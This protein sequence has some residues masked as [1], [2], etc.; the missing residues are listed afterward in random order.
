MSDQ[1]LGNFNDSE[2][3][4][5]DLP[6]EEH[7]LLGLLMACD[8]TSGI[9]SGSSQS[10]PPPASSN[11]SYPPPANLPINQ[12]PT[13]KKNLLSFQVPLTTRPKSSTRLNGQVI[14]TLLT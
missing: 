6:P 7:D 12:E 11:G 13:N 8:G 3:P 14:K 10:S 4:P 9:S 1:A 5:E 2:L